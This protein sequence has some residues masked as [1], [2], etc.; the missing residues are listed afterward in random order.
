MKKKK[1]EAWKH[2]VNVLCAIIMVLSYVGSALYMQLYQFDN[3]NGPALSV[4][5]VHS[6]YIMYIIPWLVIRHIERKKASRGTEASND[7]DDNND[8]DVELGTSTTKSTEST[9]L[10]DKGANEAD[11][12]REEA[13]NTDTDTE[14]EMAA[15]LPQPFTWKD[16]ILRVAFLSTVSFLFEW[17]W[18]LS[19]RRTSASINVTIYD[20]SSAFVYILSLIMLNEVFSFTKAFAVL[21]CVI[22][23]IIVAILG[24]GTPSKHYSV[25]SSYSSFVTESETVGDWLGYLE[26]MISVFLY[27]LYTVLYSKICIDPTQPNSIANSF[28]T[29]WLIGICTLLIDWVFVLFSYYTGLDEYVKDDFTT[30]AVSGL[31]VICLINGLYCASCLTA[32]TLSGPI[33]VSIALLLS[34]PVSIVGDAVLSG[35]RLSFLGYV[36]VIFIC[37]GFV[38]IDFSQYYPNIYERCNRKW[39][40]IPD[41]DDVHENDI[42]NNNV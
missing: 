27:S 36:G 4:Y 30:E 32:I 25:S 2:A 26:L 24:D 33:W 35:F 20:T 16:W 12:E 7:T 17:T 19:L 14:G 15:F 42:L 29:S 11:D 37:I 5:A 41:S 38:I 39:E 13:M 21:L 1:S 10:L 34:V 23:A 8:A 31:V 40:E 18:Y 28:K 6:S 22:G 3:I 9:G